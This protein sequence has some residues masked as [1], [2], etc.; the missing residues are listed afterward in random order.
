MSVEFHSDSRPRFVETRA[1]GELIATAANLS[2]RAIAVTR[3]RVCRLRRIGRS[4]QF[5]IPVP[6]NFTPTTR[7]ALS[8]QRRAHRMTNV[9]ATANVAAQGIIYIQGDKICPR[10]WINSAR[11][12]DMNVYASRGRAFLPSLMVSVGLSAPMDNLRTRARTFVAEFSQSLTSDLFSSLLQHRPMDQS[13]ATVIA[14]F[15]W[16]LAAGSLID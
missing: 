8:T 13:W 1:I 15:I 5:F 3:H 14:I 4:I 10:T 2:T 11:S 7:R 6:V 16:I 9:A 12:A